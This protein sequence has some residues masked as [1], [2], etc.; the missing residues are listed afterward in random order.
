MTGPITE[1]VAQAFQAGDM[2]RVVA[3]VEALPASA[4]DDDETALLAYGLALHSLRRNREAAA[5]LR[6][7][8]QIEPGVPEY[9]NNLGITAQ[10]AGEFDVAEQALRRAIALAPNEPQLHYHLGLLYAQQQHWQEARACQFEA[11]RL[12]PGYVDA[13]LQGALACHACGDVPGE[14]AMLQGAAPWPP[15]A[16][17]QAL[18]LANVLSMRGEQARSFAVLDQAILPGDGASAS[19]AAW[20]LAAQRC[21]LFE[22]SNQLDQAD[23]ELA[24]IPF[25]A[26]AASSDA[27]GGLH[28][29]VWHARA[30]L[31]V[32]H[33]DH[34][35]AAQWWQAMLD[36]ADSSAQRAAAAFGLAAAL[37]KLKLPAQALAAIRLAHAE[38]LESLRHVA[39]RL[40]DANAQSLPMVDKR[41]SHREHDAWST[42]PP[43]PAAQNP[44]FVVGFPRSGTTLLEQ[45]LDAHPDFRSM[46]ERAYV[47]DLL[48]R[49]E[50]AGQ[51]YPAGLAGLTAEE[52]RMLREV[53]DGLVAQVLPDLGG[54]RLVDKN[55]LNMLALPMIM[56]LYPEARI[57]LCLRHPCDVLLSCYFLPFRS[58]SFA[59]LCSTLPRLARGYVQAFE[60]WFA[61][62]E[63]FAPRVL[64]WR[65][66]SVVERFDEHVARLGHF[67]GIE[68]VEPMKNYA[69]HA[70]GKG[71]ISTPSYVQVTQG[72]NRNA[73]NRWHAYREAFEPVLPILRPMLERLGYE[74]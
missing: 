55:P 46:D 15:Q 66:E 26:I 39:P 53:Y 1:G 50:N 63:V 27:H 32:R 18:S 42:L 65:Y 20:R 3:L 14:D 70:R 10:Q 21:L 71:F 47:Y 17:E 61:H 28:H 22:R 40:V 51:P 48:E 16:L 35:G 2:A 59:T 67:L 56:R 60:Q 30:Q 52:A 23:A 73:V 41:V 31:C 64:E 8:V 43:P 24:K 6:R 58:P 36:R 13:R 19:V 9:W 4:R 33:G 38:Q 37:D 74:A 72:V 57:I 45:M 7:L 5:A 34:A 44:V 12:A 68:D 49:M 69:E 29:D 11:V 25:D 62:V 54:K